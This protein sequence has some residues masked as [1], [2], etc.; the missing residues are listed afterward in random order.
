MI[1]LRVFLLLLLS[2]ANE[3]HLSLATKTHISIEFQHTPDN[4]F[5]NGFQF[6]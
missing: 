6:E 4:D 1:S 2:A 3:M 5:Q